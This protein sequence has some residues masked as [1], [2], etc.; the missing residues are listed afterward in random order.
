MFTE[1]THT[2]TQSKGK[3]GNAQK[4]TPNVFPSKLLNEEASRNSGGWQIKPA[5]FYCNFYPS[6]ISPSLQVQAAETLIPIQMNLQGS[7]FIRK[8][9]SQ[10]I[11]KVAAALMS[12]RRKGG[13]ECG[14]HLASLLLEGRNAT[15]P[16]PL[17]PAPP[18][19]NSFN[20][21]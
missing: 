16:S 3:Y 20:K 18:P 12:S 10:N 17:R 21:Q 14:P 1:D 8:K 5:S 13:R 9:I 2:H 19:S 4:S 6:R 11:P 15:L 7:S